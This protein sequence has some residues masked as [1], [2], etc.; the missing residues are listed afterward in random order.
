MLSPTKP[1]APVTK[2]DKILSHWVAER[3]C[4]QT[5]LTFTSPWGRER[6]QRRSYGLSGWC[7]TPYRTF[8]IG[9]ALVASSSKPTT[10]P[11]Q[12]TQ[13]YGD[14][15]VTFACV[16]DGLRSVVD[17]RRNVMAAGGY[18]W[19]D[20]G[21]VAFFARH[22]ARGD[23]MKPIIAMIIVAAV[24]AMAAP[25]YGLSSGSIVDQSLLSDS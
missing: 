15:L 10:I 22:P 3:R 1:L 17:H 5:A 18:P 24:F 8:G 6:R 20:C 13:L 4:G 23:V 19:S 2:T 25:A 21:R 9:N 16:A 11:C 12:A 14:R 7:A